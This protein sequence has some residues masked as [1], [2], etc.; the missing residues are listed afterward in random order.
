MPAP[1]TNA[2]HQKAVIWPALGYDTDG[3]VK[4]GAPEE[5]TVRWVTHRGE[6]TDGLGHTISLDARV[7]V[8]Q[9]V[10]VGSVMWLGCLADWVGT[11]SG[12]DDSELHRVVRFNHTKDIKGRAIRRTCDLRRESDSLPPSA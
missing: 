1:E 2:R 4:V 3:R 5:I 12:G 6:A 11:G 10:R 8:N 9:E 7:V